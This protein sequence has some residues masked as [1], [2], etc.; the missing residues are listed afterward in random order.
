MAMDSVSKHYES[1]L[2]PIYSWMA[3]G[4]GA[5]LERG[6]QE[7]LAVCPRPSK[8]QLAI[9]L[10]AGFGMHSIALADLGY[11]VVAIDSSRPL[12]E[13]LRSQ[14]GSRP[15]RTLEGDLL[16]FRRSIEMPPNL[17]LCMG[18]TLTHLESPAVVE[19]LFSEVADSLID[20]GR[21]IATFRDY[22]VALEGVKRFIPVR[23]DAGRILTCFLDYQDE[24]VTVYD[25]L[26]ERVDS[27][28]QQ[29]I[30][31]YC[32]LRLSVGWVVSALEARG[33]QVRHE[34]GL[35][36]MVRILAQCLPRN[37]TG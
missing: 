27:G 11:S 25:I 23:S 37:I 30:S 20:G 19:T 10:G 21:F 33:F 34:P 36:G 35:G 18:D 8:N 13:E 9:D 15:I 3:G 2:A 28:W 12:L 17:V 1:H 16:D 6:C 26:H 22:S 29:R 4:V 5:A 7:V 14:A 24:T 32:K 31:S